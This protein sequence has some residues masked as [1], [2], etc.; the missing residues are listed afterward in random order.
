MIEVRFD[1]IE[2]P[3]PPRRTAD[4]FLAIPAV[5]S[6]VGVFGYTDPST[7]QKRYEYRSPE[8]VFAPAS[9]ASLKGRTLTLTHPPRMLTSETARHYSIGHVG[10]DVRLDYEGGRVL[11]TVYV[12]DKAAADAIELRG[13]RAISPG[14]RL[15]ALER[16]DG[17]APGPRGGR[18]THVQRGITYNHFALLPAGRQ[19][20]TGLVERFDAPPLDDSGQPLPESQLGERYDA[21]ES[22]TTN[23]GGSAARPKEPLMRKITIGREVVELE[24]H[25]ADLVSDALT[26]LDAA[27]A[28]VATLVSEK[29]A[30]EA[31]RDAALTRADAAEAKVTDLEKERLDGADLDALV[32]ERDEAKRVAAALKVTASGS[33]A[34]IRKACVLA[35]HGQR[36]GMKDKIERYDS[37][38]IDAAFEVVSAASGGVH[39]RDAASRQVPAGPPVPQR[40]SA[41]D[42]EAAE[43]AARERL[44]GGAKKA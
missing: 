17:T 2:T 3:Q 1:T 27:E 42:V 38:A 11:G 12:T 20:V 24:D 6:A 21:A 28:K 25:V 5:L 44:T 4:G 18:H 37:A 32:A 14:Y 39:A 19:G 34:D 35:Y 10:D 7:G 23:L 22:D 33:T 16:R 43:A 30:A 29:G 41:A 36:E 31:A 9:I 26:R 15:S 8:E 13:V 40:G